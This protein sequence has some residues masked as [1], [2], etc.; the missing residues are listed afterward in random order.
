MVKVSLFF[1]GAVVAVLAMLVLVILP[2][3]HKPAGDEWW[4]AYGCEGYVYNK[5]FSAPTM[6]G[7]PDNCK[8]YR[9]EGGYT[10]G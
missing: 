7:L 2:A 3:E 4:L 6:R 1:S 8:E 9:L 5:E 10:R